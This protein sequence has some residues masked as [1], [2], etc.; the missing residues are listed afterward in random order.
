MTPFEN[1]NPPTVCVPLIRVG[2]DGLLVIRRKL[3]DGY[4]KWCLPGGFQEM[5]VSWEQ[6]LTDET[7]QETGYQ[8]DPRDWELVSFQSIEDNRKNLLFARYV[9][10]LEGKPWTEEELESNNEVSAIRT[11][12]SWEPM[13]WAFPLHEAAARDFY[14][15][16]IA[17]N[18]GDDY[19]P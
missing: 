15:K 18:Y 9:G 19:E 4:G 6:T 11:W 10:H 12:H 7:L 5:G 3:K 17:V 16:H 13:E 8:T 14:S 2:N 1:W